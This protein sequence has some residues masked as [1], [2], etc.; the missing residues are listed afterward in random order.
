M[1]IDLSTVGYG[2][3]CA[4]FGISLVIDSISDNER[5][6]ACDKRGGYIVKADDSWFRGEKKCLIAAPK[7]SAP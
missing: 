4:C 6:H 3:L 7:V 1:K 2:I 5:R